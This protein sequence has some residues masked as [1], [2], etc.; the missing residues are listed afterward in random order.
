MND[1]G[2]LIFIAVI[3]LAIGFAMGGLF[4]NTRTERIVEESS[5]GERSG[6]DEVAC[7]W[8]DGQKERLT[9]EIN[10]RTI[11]SVDDLT[12]AERHRLRRALAELSHLDSSPATES[13]LV[14]ELPASEAP[15]NSE[16]EGRRAS[17]N[18]LEIF[19]RGRASET[20]EPPK[21]I[22]AQIDAILNKKITGTK[23][24]SRGIRLMESP[25]KGVV[26]LV[27]LEQYDS[28]EEVPDEEIRNL[29]RSCVAE[30]EQHATED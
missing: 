20:P 19:T 16:D 5:L 21:S 30:W 18:P 8:W 14:G 7:L 27:G 12:P 4:F 10:G 1:F 3:G 22:A 13:R 28:V 15:G 25:E 9:I 23:W 11:R 6:M 26:V 29:L 24:E 17:F 2:L